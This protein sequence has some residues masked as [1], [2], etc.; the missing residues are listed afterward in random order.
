M[1]GN[2]QGPKFFR[3]SRVISLKTQQYHRIINVTSMQLN[4]FAPISLLELSAGTS[5]LVTMV[6]RWS[7]VWLLCRAILFL[8]FFCLSFSP[9]WIIES[10]H[11]NCDSWP[12]Y[13]I[14]YFSGTIIR[15]STVKLLEYEK[16]YICCRCKQV[17]AIQ[18]DFE[19]HYSIPKPSKCPSSKECKSNKFTCLSES[20]MFSCMSSL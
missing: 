20:G 6:F 19:Q 3:L 5:K 16:E 18:A 13:N 12:T 14:I 4:L 2:E 1:S 7:Q 9:I 15:V 10:F 17:F 8:F 11:L